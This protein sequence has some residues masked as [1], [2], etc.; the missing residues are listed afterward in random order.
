MIRQQEGFGQLI[1]E[2]LSSVAISGVQSNDYITPHTS[3]LTD[4]M[5]AQR[6][7]PQVLAD[8]DVTGP[9]ISPSRLSFVRRQFINMFP[10][11]GMFDREAA[12]DEAHPDTLEWIF[13][14]T[15]SDTDR[16]CNFSQW[17]GS[18]D[19]LY[20]ITGKM[21]SGKSTLMKFISEE[22]PETSEA[23][24]VRRCTPCLLQWARDQPLFI[25][26]FYF[27]AGSNEGTRIQTSVQGL[28]RTLL[29]QI[30]QAYP[31]SAPHVSPQRWE[32]LCLFSKN[33]KPPAI[34]ELKDMLS[35]AIKYVSSISK[36]C[37][38]IDG[39]DEL[40]GET[41]D[42]KGL[43]AWVEKLV[44]TSPA[45]VCVASRP[46]R[47][48]EETLQHRPHL[49][50]EAFNF[51]DIQQYVWSRFNIDSNFR[52][53]KQLDA[54]F[55]N[56]LVDEIIAKAEGVFLWVRIVCTHLLE[57]MSRGDLVGDL[58]RILNAV[59]VE[60]EKLYDHILDSLD[61]EDHAAKYFLLL[62]TCFQRPDALIFSFAD[63]IGGDNNFS[64]NMPKASLTFSQLQYR[65]TELRKRLNSRCKGL[66]SLT[67]AR[68]DTTDKMVYLDMGAIQ[69]CHRSAKDYLTMD[70]V[71][72]KLIRMLDAPFDPHLTL[73][74]AYL[75][76]WKCGAN[77]D[78]KNTRRVDICGCLEHAAK[79]F[80]ESHDM[81]IRV[82]EEM[83]SEPVPL[84][85]FDGTYHEDNH[86]FG[87][88][89]LCCAVVLGVSEY[90]KFKVGERQ[91]CVV[92]TSSFYLNLQK[93]KNYSGKW[94]SATSD[95]S[96]SI[97][98]RR[99]KASIQK[100][101][102]ARR[103]EEV[104]WPLLL[105]ALLSA[106]YPD[107]E[108]VSLLLEN[109]ANPN[110]II[111]GAGWQM[112][113]FPIVSS[114][115]FASL[116]HN[117]SLSSRERNVWADSIFLLLQRGA[118]PARSDLKSFREFMGRN[119]THGLKAPHIGRHRDFITRFWSFL[120]LEARKG[121]LQRGLWT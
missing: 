63:D 101:D 39:L 100:F 88:T 80:S 102:R 45:K 8:A 114:L 34:Q 51:N 33:S 15:S 95:T 67:E 72:D 83:N 107:T 14:N 12:L 52:A 64:L 109:G 2:I 99:T 90:V 57:A 7:C 53:K 50:M 116:Q 65:L 86:A 46:W 119:L 91:G 62:Q 54:V 84:V 66:L 120:V 110:L 113:A 31:E 10:Y 108:M 82:L 111:R 13:K 117:T 22:L 93:L 59:P 36:V 32:K 103:D 44:E 30:L 42:L 41:G 97:T 21:G 29:V 18:E 105:D 43:V 112:S 106:S 23:G 49:L 9:Q 71:R 96:F 24:S 118:K 85:A 79:V 115:L 19:K 55:C 58:K 60:M 73:C 98:K 6:N 78:A 87:G 69:Y 37:L 61:H 5:D 4:L 76:R 92:R 25:A 121:T 77:S 68:L 70:T 81:M 94:T 75:A 17:L 89:L 28:Y 104:E 40:E 3:L 27:W 26:T 56:Q 1:V 38:F 11:D 20:W 35:N 16:W 48:F 74:S 47:V